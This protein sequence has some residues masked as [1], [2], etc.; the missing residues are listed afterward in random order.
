MKTTTGTA[1]G[2][3]KGGVVGSWQEDESDAAETRDRV[4]DDPGHSLGWARGGTQSRSRARMSLTGASLVPPAG[5]P[6][7]EDS[8][9]G[10][11]PDMSLAATPHEIET[12][13][14]RP[15]APVPSRRLEAAAALAT[16][17]DAWCAGA[18]IA[19]SSYIHQTSPDGPPPI[20]SSSRLHA[21]ALALQGLGVWGRFDVFRA[22]AI[23]VAALTGT[24][25]TRLR[26]PGDATAP[27]DATALPNVEA[28][29]ETL[30]KTAASAEGSEPQGTTPVHAETH[31]LGYTRSTAFR[32]MMIG[33]DPLP[34]S[35][36]A[37]R[38]V[39]TLAASDL[40][41]VHAASSVPSPP[42]TTGTTTTT[43]TAAG[44]A[45]A[46]WAEPDAPAPPSADELIL[47]TSW[48]SQSLNIVAG[49][50]TAESGVTG[51][52]RELLEAL[53]FRALLE[54]A[55]PHADARL[56]DSKEA[57][58]LAGLPVPALGSAGVTEAPSIEACRRVPLPPPVARAVE[59]TVT[60]DD[61]ERL[62]REATSSPV[63]T[64]AGDAAAAAE[65]GPEQPG[66]REA[67]AT[68]ASGGHMEA[69]SEEEGDDEEAEDSAANAVA[70]PSASAG[71]I[72]PQISSAIS[73]RSSM[74]SQHHQHHHHHSSFAGAWPW[75][76]EVDVHPGAARRLAALLTC[77]YRPNFYHS[78]VHASDVLQGTRHLLIAGGYGA[79]LSPQSRV[80]LVL[81]A[82]AHDVGH[83]GVNNQFITT[84]MHPL[85]LRYG[86]ESPLERMHAASLVEMIHAY[87]E[88]D[89]MASWS[90]QHR[91]TALRL[92]FGCIVH[93]DNAG[94]FAMVDKLRARAALLAPTGSVG[95][96]SEG[97][98]DAEAPAALGS[99]AEGR[100]GG[101][102]LDLSPGHDDEL[103]VTQ[104]VLH[105]ADISNPSRPWHLN[106][107]WGDFVSHEFWLQGLREEQAGL[108]V[109][110]FN[111]SRRAA[112]KPLV[113]AGFAKAFCLPLLSSVGALGVVDVSEWMGNLRRNVAAC[114]VLGQH[115][116]AALATQVEPQPDAAEPA[117]QAAQPPVP[118][119]AAAIK[120]PRTP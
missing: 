3:A 45:A 38:T 88:A 31:G 11:I 64:T 86:E 28:L 67:L 101:G 14:Y 104:A 119:P 96:G 46:P 65:G 57:A 105:A 90:S 62:V 39:A 85:A 109:A 106:C 4:E 37:A 68:P 51:W 70:V 92:A 35:T 102:P 120:P 5:I 83:P 103:L 117:P 110:A 2:I 23:L 8:E 48:H 29:P 99:E 6:P 56:W 78:A 97:G 50:V 76:W 81:A 18:G 21:E 26:L 34:I 58:V 118:P 43:G 113:Q 54:A 75:E 100:G 17:G 13:S 80:A 63:S 12:G 7:A 20:P 59:E 15:Q 27:H 71:E 74:G 89:V 9:S 114:E 116:K 82:A 66:A 36:E 49:G 108:P 47:G 72:S 77:L 42:T 91:R 19:A 79:S 94:H 112:P 98:P 61:V 32:D 95:A 87:P 111:D 53:T 33:P 16:D 93:T 69:L 25:G 24:A 30:G 73:S 1:G 40:S 115:V 41:A 55:A 22:N 10:S 52:G 60:A 107:R 44:G 84:T